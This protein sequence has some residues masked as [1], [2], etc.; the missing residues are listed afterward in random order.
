MI[1][2]AMTD[3]KGKA[4]AGRFYDTFFVNEYGKLESLRAGRYHSSF[5]VVL[6]NVDGGSKPL[7]DEDVQEFL[8][9]LSP[10][11]LDSMRSCDVVGMIDERQVAAILP[12]TDYFGSLI[13][14]RKLSRAI[15][16]YLVNE[17]PPVKKLIFSQATFPKDG[18]GYGALLSTAAKRMSEKK[19]SLWEKKGFATKLFWEIIGELTGSSYKGFDNSSFDA[20][21]G[22]PLQ[23]SFIDQ[24]NELIIR[25]IVAAPHKRGIAYFSSRG[26]TTAFPMMSMLGHIGTLSTKVFVVGQG[27]DSFRDIKNATPIFIDDPRLKEVF[28]SFY[29]T[30]DSGYCLVCKENWGSTYSCFH[31]S[32]HYLVDGLIN[33]FQVE[34]SLQEQL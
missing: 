3:G 27:D 22:Y 4:A 24:I 11:V 29:L 33:K 10:M 9:R 26:Q 17:P 13:S 15:N 16:N 8:K 12:E 23:E 31:S 6:M 34:Y 14:I 19:E 1:T 18:K 7:A 30:E 2:D 25:E 28:F 32:D 20:G 21:G 5:S